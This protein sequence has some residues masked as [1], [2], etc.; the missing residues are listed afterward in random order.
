MGLP[1]R[2]ERLYA[3]SAALAA[4]GWLAAATAAGPFTPPLPQALI[5]G[6]LVLSVPWWA[7]RR[8]RAKVRVER[9]LTAWPEIAQSVGLPG[10]QV[11]S[12]VVDLWGWRCRIRLARGQTITDVIA[13][14]PGLE[15][16]LG[17]F[18]GAIR[19]YPTLDDLANRCELRVLEIDPHAGAIPWPGPS[20]TSITEPV[21][22][23]PFEDAAPVPGAVPA[24]A[25]PVRRQHRL[26][27]KRRPQRAPRQPRG[28]PRRRHLGHR[29]EEGHGASAVGLLHRAARHHSRAGPRATGRRRGHPGSPRRPARRRG[30]PHLGAVP[31]RPGPGDHHR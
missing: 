3:A 23:G 1:T 30:T 27:Q 12:A 13:K 25:R 18:R 9:K 4:G 24:P 14:I 17:T 7:H 22:L 21:E 19:V 26:R 10:S 15:S 5:L 16:A 20:V 8:R 2:S 11:M 6:G 29:P 28:L 31:G